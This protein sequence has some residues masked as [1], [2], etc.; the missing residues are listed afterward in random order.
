MVRNVESSRD[1]GGGEEGYDV[2]EEFGDL[3]DSVHAGPSIG[4]FIP[5]RVSED[6]A[7]R[8]RLYSAVGS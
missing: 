5:M 1:A 7:G 6:W 2:N 3:P 4:A 8:Y